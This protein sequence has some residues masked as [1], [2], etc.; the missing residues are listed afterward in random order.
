MAAFVFRSS[1]FINE[2]TVY[3]WDVTLRYSKP[4]RLC[5]SGGV[6][7]KNIH[8]SIILRDTQYENSK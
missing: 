8:H 1:I 3:E 2:I 6:G 4:A 5:H 7:S